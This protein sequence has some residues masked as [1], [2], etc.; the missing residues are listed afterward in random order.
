MEELV[1]WKGGLH[2]RE[3]IQTC[4]RAGRMCGRVSTSIRIEN[5]ES[6]KIL[7]DFETRYNL[8]G[9]VR[10]NTKSFPKTTFAKL[11]SN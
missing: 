7:Q 4:Q 11:A 5:N 10:P 2:V 3:R 1:A 9:S 8:T 6:T